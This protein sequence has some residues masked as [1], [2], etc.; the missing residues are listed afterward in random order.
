MTELHSTHD[1]QNISAGAGAPNSIL[2]LWGAEYC[3]PGVQEMA[4]L[5]MSATSTPSLVLSPSSV[6]LLTTNISRPWDLARLNSS[7]AIP[8]PGR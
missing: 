6:N 7:R 5:A 4:A 8:L 2:Q 1:H 3:V